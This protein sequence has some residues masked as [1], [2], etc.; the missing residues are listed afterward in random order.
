MPRQFTLYHDLCLFAYSSVCFVLLVFV[1]C[2]VYPNDASVTGLPFFL[3]FL[4]CSLAFI[5]DLSK[6]TWNVV[7]IGIKNHNPYRNEKPSFT[8]CN[9][10]VLW[11]RALGILF[12]FGCVFI[13]FL[14]WPV[15]NLTRKRFNDLCYSSQ[16][17]L[18]YLRQGIVIIFEILCNRNNIRRHLM[19]EYSLSCEE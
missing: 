17:K 13:L 10:Y 1:L 8:P 19:E 3:L 7:E 9:G 16:D 4:R 6:N 12:R 14:L 2:I 11:V 5:Y 15:R 18:Y